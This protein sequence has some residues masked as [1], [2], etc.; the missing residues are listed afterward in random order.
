MKRWLALWILLALWPALA[1]GETI[2]VA[3]TASFKKTLQQLKPLFTQQS[4]HDLLIS[5]A[6]SGTL[7]AQIYNGAPYQL[8]LAADDRYPQRLIEAELAVP[9]SRFV[10]ALGRLVLFCP[11]VERLHGGAN[12]LTTEQIRRITLA[13]PKTAPYGRAAR[14]VLMALNLWSTFA[15]RIAF[16]E[17]V[18]QSLAF[19]QSGA[20]DAGFVAYSQLLTADFTPL[21][22]ALWEPPAHLYQPLR[23]EGVRLQRG[24]GQTAVSQLIVFLTAAPTQATIVSLGFG[25]PP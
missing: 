6:S 22:G 13:N 11:Q 3:V 20:V 15:G 23:H 17:N 25:T 5:S 18:G 10:Y 19:V 14:E 1:R 24:M 21:P 12:A 4:G 2:H 8:F 7:Y 9:G 16:G